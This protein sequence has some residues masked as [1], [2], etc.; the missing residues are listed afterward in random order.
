MTMKKKI[1]RFQSI[2]KFISYTRD[3]K[4]K[5]TKLVWARTKNRRK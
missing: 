5:Q 3:N 4:V 2:K 1:G